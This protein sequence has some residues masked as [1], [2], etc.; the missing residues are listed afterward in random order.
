M[1]KSLTDVA[2]R[3]PNWTYSR[4]AVG[5]NTWIST[6]GEIFSR[7][8]KAH[9]ERKGQKGQMF[10]CVSEWLQQ[11]QQKPGPSPVMNELLLFFLTCSPSLCIHSPSFCICLFIQQPTLL[12]HPTDVKVGML[13]LKDLLN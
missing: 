4:V 5:R 13:Y 8:S 6:R 10:A 12:R 2:N 9:A 11:I 7:N 1:I 3:G